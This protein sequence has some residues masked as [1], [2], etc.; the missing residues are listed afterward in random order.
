MP[1]ERPTFHESWYRV[2]ELHP[3]LRSTVQITRQHYRGQPWHVVQDHTNNAFFR[4]SEPAYHF[5]G[6]LDGQR[7]VGDAWKLCNEQ[8][9]DDAP[10]QGETIQLLGQLY[11]SNLLQAE[12]PADTYGLF[13]RYKK[14]V[15][16]ELQSYLM[17]LMF[18]RIPLLDPDRFLEKWMPLFGWIFSWFGLVVWL[19]LMAAAF[20]SLANVPNWTTELFSQS[21]NVLNP[22]NLI[23][24]Y[25]CFAV[26]KG[27][28]EFGHAFSCRKFGITSGV[29][30][31]VHTMGIMFLIFSPVPYVD[32]SSSWAL[33]SKWQRVMVGAAGMWVELA[34]AS[35]AAIVWANTE[36]LSLPHQLAYNIMFVA[37]VSTVMFNANPL[38]RY[39]GYYMLSD[40]LEIPNLA[41]RSKEYF[42]YLVKRYVWNMRQP[43]PRNP[44]HSQSESFWLFHYAWASFTMRIVVSF[45]IMFYL[46]SVLNGVLIILAVAMGLAG[47]V[48][49][50]LVPIGKFIHYLTT[51]PE[52]ARVRPRAVLTTLAFVAL[53]TIGLGMIPA[54]DHVRAQG[55][56]RC[57]EYRQQEINAEAD[58]F[59]TQVL[60]DSQADLDPVYG[61]P[62]LTTASVIYTSQNEQL[63]QEL[64]GL[65]AQQDG[66]K[67]R[68]NMALMEEHGAIASSQRMVDTL[69]ALIDAKQ[70][71]L[72]HLTRKSP[73]AGLLIA[74]KL[75]EATGR[76]IKQ[77]EKI[78]EVKDLD[79]NHLMI[80]AT[81]S[82]QY[83]G[84]LNKE[85]TNEVE[86]RVLGRPDMLLTGTMTVL[87]AGQSQLPS[88]AL[89]FGAGGQMAVNRDD[90]QGTKTTEDFFQVMVR[91]LKFVS[92]GPA[93]PGARLMPEQRVMVRFN[94]R[95]K[96]LVPRRGRASSK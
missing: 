39:D 94:L 80:V 88:R 8:L 64:A 58:G 54:P 55:F 72:D 77:G 36:A 86:I 90:R 37:S 70:K 79:L 44:A 46:A 14:R 69:Q 23:G 81:V 28:H 2:A 50:I 45:S 15:R 33:R 96:S 9:G 78:G 84:A 71:Q 43:V 93:D 82:N 1:F 95:S 31:E 12:L 20:H 42:Y 56:V 48:T 13:N 63:R 35:I 40:L 73:Q 68:Y 21:S 7:S 59:V 29:G 66:W 41:Q 51:S 34:I 57:Q 3:R 18:I 62:R 19:G 26:I 49:W 4:L 74:P 52:L 85:A 32:A 75:D 6:L 24:L 10:T 5:L 16:R 11:T 65:R 87:P 61:V 91:D 27:C 47:V 53:A 38:L 89:S 25:I 22:N 92:P 60:T 76:Y 67:T 30:G 17:N 83:S